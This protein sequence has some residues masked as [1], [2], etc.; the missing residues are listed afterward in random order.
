MSLDR[1]FSFFFGFPLP[2]ISF[3]YF[4]TL[5]NFVSFNFIRSCDD[6]TGVLVRHPCYSQTFNKGPSTHLISRPGPVSDSSLGYLFILL[7]F[8]LKCQFSD[9][10]FRPRRQRLVFAIMHCLQSLSL[11]HSLQSLM[12]TI[13]PQKTKRNAEF[14]EIYLAM[15]TL[16]LKF[17][18]SRSQYEVKYRCLH[19][20]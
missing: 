17:V 9:N 19:Y 18:S 1:V 8:P 12:I 4:S 16:Y 20:S 10:P 7:I 6:A 15:R 3:H 14:N 13:P 2:Q 11:S 5:V